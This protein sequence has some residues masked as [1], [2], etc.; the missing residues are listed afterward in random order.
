VLAGGVAHADVWPVR[1]TVDA[2]IRTVAFHPDQVVRLVGFVGY[3]LDLEFAPDET[4]EGLS[5]G[6]LEALSYAAHGPVLTLK[7]KAAP[8]EMNLAVTTNRRRYYFDYAVL[9]RR[10]QR[11]LDEVMYAVRFTYPPPAAGPDR[12]AR[13][14]RALER[15][16][17]ARPRNLDYGYCGH[18]SLKPRAASDDGVHTRLTFGSRQEL[19]AL[20]V[21]HA[22]G[23]ESLLNF[24][25]EDGDVVIHR[26]AAQFVVRRGRL[27][28]CIVNRGFAGGAARLDS[29]TV[30]PDVER[31]RRAAPP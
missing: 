16:S 9:A 30:A 17:A 2:R 29:G 19:P 8:A 12:D 4:F 11:G 23:T 1:G 22:D 28:G 14:E 31:A 21:R 7:P 26:V 25:V 3:H 5:G 20:F 27:A 18:R 6:D 24:H 10:P 15:A 13:I